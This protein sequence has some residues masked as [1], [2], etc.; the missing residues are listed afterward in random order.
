MSWKTERLISL[1]HS[2]DVGHWSRT[3]EYRSDM[4]EVGA[5][6]RREV[7]V[8]EPNVTKGD[9]DY[10]QVSTEHVSSVFLTATFINIPNKDE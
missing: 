5:D 2:D 6:F 10:A 4:E 1:W 3:F 8:E 9:Y 7:L